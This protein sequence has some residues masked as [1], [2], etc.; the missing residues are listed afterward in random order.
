MPGFQEG[1]GFSVSR[2]VGTTSTTLPWVSELPGSPSLL[3]LL[4]RTVAAG[5]WGAAGPDLGAALQATTLEVRPSPL[6]PAARAEAGFL[7]ASQEPREPWGLPAFRA[8]SNISLASQRKE[9]NA[10]HS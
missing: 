3:P 2:D 1:D 7:P 9:R 8:T 10:R 4:R 6:P 5:C